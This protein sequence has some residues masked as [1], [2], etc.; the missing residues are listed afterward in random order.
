MAWQLNAT[1][2]F[3]IAII[4][5]G[6]IGF[7]RGWRREVVTLAFVLTGV[8][9]LYLN[10][11]EYVAKF[12]FQ[13]LPRIIGF[14]LT[15]KAPAPLPNPSKA[16]VTVT[17]LVTFIVIVT[18]GFIVGNRAFENAK[19]P[20]DHILGVIPGIITGFAI[21]SSSIFMGSTLFTL[22][23]EPINLN[24]TGSYMLVIFI[25]ALVAL[26]LG[27]ISASAKKSSGGKS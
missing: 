3:Y 18:M 7:M 25:V 23:I 12:L 19:V 15:E 20:A 27:L 13:Y 10:G 24:S 9:F 8:L 17:T 16:A 21:I 14:V 5:F 4:A 6:V 26:V 11:G 22:A 1:E 2:L